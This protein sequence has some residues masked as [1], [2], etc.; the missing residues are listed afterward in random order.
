MSIIVSLELIKMHR[1]T[2]I[3]N[4]G[5]SY[6]YVSMQNVC[7]FLLIHVAMSIVRQIIKFASIFILEFTI[8]R[9]TCM[10]IIAN[11]CVLAIDG[12]FV[13][14]T[15]QFNDDKSNKPGRRITCLS[16]FMIG[17][18]GVEAVW[19]IAFLY[20]F[21]SKITINNKRQSTTIHKAYYLW[22]HEMYQL[23]VL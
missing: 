8:L 9:F 21:F 11:L 5:F 14:W 12:V 1:T 22:H 16:D 19:T 4:I 13:E 10:F 23:V 3:F 15:G 6:S 2:R 20:I 17:S 18:H 7:I